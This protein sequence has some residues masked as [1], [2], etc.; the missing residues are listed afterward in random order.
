[1]FNIGNEII[2]LSL[3]KGTRNTPTTDQYYLFK[4]GKLIAKDKSFRKL[5]K[6]FDEIYSKVPRLCVDIIIKSEDGILL[7]LRSIE[8]YEGKWHIP[9]GQYI[10]EKD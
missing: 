7:P 10:K 2:N 3:E 5:K 1:M 8:P 4:D 6:L 9:G